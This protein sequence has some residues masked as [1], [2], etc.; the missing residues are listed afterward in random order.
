[1]SVVDIVKELKRS[2]VQEMDKVESQ[3]DD[4][5]IPICT[6]ETLMDLLEQLDEC[7]MTLEILV[8]TKI[9]RVV[10]KLKRNTSVGRKAKA[11]V[12][13]WRAL[14]AGM[15]HSNRL[16]AP[17]ISNVVDPQVD[18][19]QTLLSHFDEFLNLDKHRQK[20]VITLLKTLEL[21]KKSLVQV[22]M[23]SNTV[24]NLLISR[25]LEIEN[26]LY[27]NFMEVNTEY[28]SMVSSLCNGLRG[29]PLLCQATILGNQV[30]INDLMSVSIGR[31]NTDLLSSNVESLIPSEMERSRIMFYSGSRHAYP[32]KGASETLQRDDFEAG[33]FDELN[34]HVGFR[35]KLSNFY[36]IEGYNGGFICCGRSWRTVEHCFQG[37]K[38]EV[39][40]PNYCSQFALNSGSPL[41]HD[42]GVAARRA[43]GKKGKRPLAHVQLRDWD[44]RKHQVMREAM[45]ARY[46]QDEES[47]KILL[48]TKNAILLHRP[49]RSKLVVM[50]DLMLV[51]DMLQV[52]E[53]EDMEAEHQKLS[54]NL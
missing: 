34:S 15:E 16:Q 14:V 26:K 32:G 20:T 22:G 18:Q 53:E 12:K 45:Y 24:N 44:Q 1:M 23:R 51:R 29:G 10:S 4:G 28:E 47:K 9:G 37:R 35:Q 54:K 41:S 39:V 3:G 33:V 31:L 42:S 49:P 13:K 36:E 21:E 11:L 43:G 8:E 25:S 7:N 5:H 19:V 6:G 50:R 52:E 48:A 2:L 27:S 46:S 40:D 30:Q 38:F 17:A